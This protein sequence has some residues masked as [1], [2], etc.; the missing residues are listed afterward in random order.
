MNAN[1]IILALCQALLIS[2]N[3]LLVSVNALIGTEL[4]PSSSLITLPVALQFI[5]LMCATIPAS[6]IM[7]KVGRKRGFYL[8]NL[9]GIAGA[10]ASITGLYNQSFTMF[11]LGTT[12]LGVGIGFGNLYRFAAVEVCHPDY[13]AR[14]ISMTLAGGVLAAVLGPNLAIYSRDWS[15]EQP[16]IGAFIGLLGLYVL[17]LILLS[18]IRINNSTEAPSNQQARPLLDILKQPV[19]FVAVIAGIVGYGVMVLVMTATPLA[20]THHG[21]HFGEAAVVIE[22]HVLGMFV[23]SFF[24]GRLIERFG[25]HPMMQLGGVLTLLCLVIN[26]LGQSYLHFLIALVLLGVGW[27]F[28]FISA[29]QLVTQAYTAAEKAKSQAMN[30]FL[31]FSTVSVAALASGW[32]EAAWGWQEMNLLMIP[33]VVGCMLII[34]S[35]GRKQSP[36]NQEVSAKS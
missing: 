10:L 34:Q 9:V 12:L 25:I 31:V 6:F 19:F 8:G 32:L 21:F 5:G 11:C 3:I 14:A 23:P 28:L 30:E 4:A 7:Q 13:K 35:Y 1:V 24:T 17:A 29:T 22:W 20:M 27:N 15:S 2:G 18:R 33:I 16:F 26:L 36:V